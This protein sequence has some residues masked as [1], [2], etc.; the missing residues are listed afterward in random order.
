MGYGLVNIC[1]VCTDHHAFYIMVDYCTHIRQQ[2]Q[3]TFLKLSFVAILYVCVDLH[4]S[5]N[6]FNHAVYEF[7]LLN[8][9]FRKSN[10][11]Q[12]YP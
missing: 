11:N 7:H 6:I 2:P 8:D 10:Q 5:V 12:C 3:T 9:T 4:V 1:A